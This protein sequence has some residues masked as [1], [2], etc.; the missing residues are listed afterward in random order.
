MSPPPP[1]SP[2]SAHLP[3][4]PGHHDHHHVRR[5]VA[6]APPPLPPKRQRDINSLKVWWNSPNSK[7]KRRVARYKLYAMEGKVKSSLKKSCRWVKQTCSRI[8]TGF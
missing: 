7:R 4:P 6:L 2:P 8:I 5:P 1:R 3:S